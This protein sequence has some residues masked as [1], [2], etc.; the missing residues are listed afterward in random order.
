MSARSSSGLPPI[1]VTG[2]IVPAGLVPAATP[3]PSPVTTATD[4]TVPT[5]AQMSELMAQA[6]TDATE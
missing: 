3:L 1:T 6:A 2:P 4:V 5:A